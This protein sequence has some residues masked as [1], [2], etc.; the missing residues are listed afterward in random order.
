MNIKGKETEGLVLEFDVARM[1]LAE[2]EEEEE[3]RIVVSLLDVT[4]RKRTEEELKQSE[5][6]YR[7]IVETVPDVIYTLAADDGRFTSLN[8]A[9]ETITGW[10]RE[11]WVGKTFATLVHPEDMQ[12]ATGTFQQVLRGEYPR[13]YELRILAKSGE[14]L[15]GE[16]TS[17]PHFKEGKI[18][19]EL[20]I[21]RDITERKLL[22]KK[23]INSKEQL[24][25]LAS[26][27]QNV[28]EEEKLEL[29][30]EL[31]DNVGQML[32][33]LQMDISFLEKN[34][35]NRNRKINTQ[36]I[37]KKFSG[38]V[39]LLNSTID[40]IREISTNLRPAILDSFGLIF[41]IE[42]YLKEFQKKKRHCL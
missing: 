22:E 18:V 41:T 13:L 15:I 40:I 2:E 16:F 14:Y 8:P 28:R 39:E 24:R 26:R 27:L 37:K 10:S 31:H 19:G 20:G 25:A 7:T 3:A 9:F 38:M 23:L 17:M 6:R 12:L 33:A 21:A 36:I 29:S 4:E 35:I 11:E 34:I 42:W 1:F 5:Q 32:T 30:R